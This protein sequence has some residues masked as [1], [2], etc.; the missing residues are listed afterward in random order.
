MYYYVKITHGD[1]FRYSFMLSCW[2]LDPVKRPT[3]SDLV[4]SLSDSL[5][6]TLGYMCSDIHSKKP[7][8]DDVIV[9]ENAERKITFIQ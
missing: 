9:N 1:V 2:E 3:F 8:K 4:K 5:A 6:D 7:N